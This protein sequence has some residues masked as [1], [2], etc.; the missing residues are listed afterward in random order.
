[1]SADPASFRDPAG[2][3]YR[4]NGRFFRTVSN[5]AAARIVEHPRLLTLRKDIFPDYTLEKFKSIVG[6]RARLAGERAVTRAGRTLIAFDR[7]GA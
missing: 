5:A 2:R 1:M 7:K 6:R 4:E 3:V